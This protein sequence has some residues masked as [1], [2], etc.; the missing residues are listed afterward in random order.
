MAYPFN[1]TLSNR[2]VIVV[3]ATQRYTQLVMASHLHTG[4][5]LDLRDLGSPGALSS[6]RKHPFLLRVLEE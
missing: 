1:K 2:T 6:A 3:E 4:Y 5:R